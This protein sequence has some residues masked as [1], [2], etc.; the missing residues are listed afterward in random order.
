MG[1][2]H[3]VGRR[4]VCGRFHSLATVH[5]SPALCLHCHP[6]LPLSLPLRTH[7][8]QI[9]KLADPFRRSGKQLLGPCHKSFHSRPFVAFRPC[10]LNTVVATLKPHCRV[11]EKLTVVQLPVF[12]GTLN[13]ITVAVAGSSYSPLVLMLV[14]VDSFYMSHQL[15]SSWNLLP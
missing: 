8:T 12:Y 10:D 11:V 7:N 15:C 13:L 2:E 14:Q 3:T 4:R 1:T 9:T 6:P 5:A